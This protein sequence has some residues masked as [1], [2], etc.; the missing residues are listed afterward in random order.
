MCARRRLKCARGGLEL[1]AL[2][3]AY[4]HS[5]GASALSMWP[6][7]RKNF[8]RVEKPANQTG[9]VFQ[10]TQELPGAPAHLRRRI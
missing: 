6:G 4:A 7:M 9:N 10:R 2:P 3:H 1:G 8:C 5:Q